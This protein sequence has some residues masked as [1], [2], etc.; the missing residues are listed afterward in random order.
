MLIGII[1][2]KHHEFPLVSKE[3]TEKVEGQSAGIGYKY[4]GGY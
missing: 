2:N 3:L 4:Q 1:G